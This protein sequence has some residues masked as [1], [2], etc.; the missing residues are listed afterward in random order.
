[1]PY[2]TLSNTVAMQA[3]SVTGESGCPKIEPEPVEYYFHCASGNGP[4]SGWI[5]KASW[6]TPPLPDGTCRYEFRMRDKSPQTN[7]TPY[8]SAETA[9]VS[10]MTGYR[11][12]PLSQLANQA[13]GA[14]VAFTGRV[15]G[16]ETNAYIVS[17]DGASIKV[18][19]QTVACATDA[20]LRDRD[21]AVKGCL[22]NRG[23]EKRVVWAE[24]K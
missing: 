9:V 3:M 23:N 21:V 19:P 6:Q 12:Y 16:V 2:A 11:E 8:S 24:L 5:T 4:D 17:A 15:T 13:E 7:E 14:L 10:N 20:T 18:M 1:M 22:W